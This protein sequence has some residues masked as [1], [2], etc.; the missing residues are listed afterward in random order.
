MAICQEHVTDSLQA[1]MK[2]DY[3]LALNSGHNIRRCIICGKY[4]ML[5]S[6][7]H[8]LYCEGACPHA[9]GYTCRQFG[10]VEVQ[11]ELAKNNPK[12]K[13]KLTAFSRITKDM[14]RGAISQEDA[15]RAKDHVRDRLYDV[16]L[17]R[18][19]EEPRIMCETGSTMR[20]AARISLLRSF[21]NKYLL[22]KCM[23]IAASPE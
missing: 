2:A 22:R 17:R 13:A 5:K 14:Q 15:R 1:L 12:V 19:P 20:C 10:T 8:A 7:V 11:K 4:F 21:L 16:S 6:G 3:M 9:P 23:N 18:M